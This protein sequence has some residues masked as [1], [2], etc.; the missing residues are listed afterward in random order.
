MICGG[1]DAILSPFALA[2]YSRA[3][4]LSLNYNHAP[5]L[6]S[7]P[8]DAQRDGFVP[9]D[10]A[11]VLVLEERDHALERGAHIYAEMLG[12]GMCSDAGGTVTSPDPNG[13]GVKLCINKALTNSDVSWKHVS[14][15]NAHATSTPTGDAAEAKGVLS[16]GPV[17]GGDVF[18]ASNKGALGHMQGAAGAVEALST[19][20]SCQHAR[21]P[22]T[23]N[24]SNPDVTGLNYVMGRA[25]DWTNEKR[26]AISTSFG[27]G[28]SCGAVVLSNHPS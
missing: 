12:Y 16:L 2:A 9:S 22:P 11:A 20:L 10:G 7:R 8:F 15:V 6:A 23:V 3:R 14:Y 19:V 18:V 17:E 26:V 4:A 24:L 5:S 25:V 28:S 1:T 21:I 13:A 27:F